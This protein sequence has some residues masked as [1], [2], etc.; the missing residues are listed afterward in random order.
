MKRRPNKKI[1]I[2]FLLVWLI[3]AFLLEST[4]LWISVSLYNPGAEWAVILEKFGE[5]PGLL[6]ALIG[7]QIYIVTLRSS[8]NSKKIL[9]TSFLLTTSSL[10]T[11]YIFFVLSN[12]ISGS[13]NF[14]NSHENY[15]FF[16]AILLNI[17]ITYLSRKHY[18]F[19]KKAIIFSRVSFNMFL[20]GY[21][22][23]VQP[24]KLFW[25]RIRFRDL[26][27][28]YS[29]FTAWYLPQGITGNDSFPS[30]HAAMGWILLSLFVFFID[31]SFRKRFILKA[32][33]ISWA[34]AVSTSRVIIGAHYS[35][36]VLFASFGMIITYLLVLS[37]VTKNLK[38]EFE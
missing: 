2:Y 21:I 8:S 4:D 29:H 12:S 36:D 30:G 15:F 35:S 17:F 26:A 13:Y 9:F 18:K 16:T 5:I 38:S 22:F 34:I 31:K 37:Y 11:I 7:A 27:G 33:I 1:V 23:F 25:G 10:I 32:L 24:L 3:C 14:F 28:N 6:V 19:S 20:Y